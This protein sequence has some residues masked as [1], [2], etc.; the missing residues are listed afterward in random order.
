[1]RKLLIILSTALGALALGK[2]PDVTAASAIVI[3]A[4][5]GKVLFS[6]NADIPRYPAST[7]KVMTG[8]LLAENTLPEDT[9]VAPS[10]V[11]AITGSKMHLKPGEKVSA[12]DMLYALMLR[13]A[14]DGCYAVALHI[15]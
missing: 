13:S 14:N 6:K 4:D 15:S 3:D 2:G 1:M 9:I 5:S 10:D 12:G 7:T 8:L 11:D